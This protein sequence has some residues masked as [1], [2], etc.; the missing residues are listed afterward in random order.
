MRRLDRV[1][2]VSEADKQLLRDLK[3]VILRFVPDATVI[4]YGSVARGKQEPESD[5]DVLVLSDRKVSR[6]EEAALDSAVYDLEL[7]REVVLSVML[8]SKDEWQS[9]VLS[10]SFYHDNVTREGILI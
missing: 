7:D 1:R 3:S 4:L 5:I 8:H 2:I 6:V 10:Q 9:P